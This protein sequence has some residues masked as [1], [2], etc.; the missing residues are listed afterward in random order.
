MHFFFFFFL[1][2]PDLR[3]FK[4]TTG[5][6]LYNKLLV[7]SITKRQGRERKEM[8]LNTFRHWAAHRCPSAT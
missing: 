2:R 3:N 8:V 1:E 5:K 7:Q 4:N 6:S